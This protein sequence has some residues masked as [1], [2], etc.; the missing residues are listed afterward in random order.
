MFT[1][2]SCT[3]LSRNFNTPNAITPDRLMGLFGVSVKQIS[4]IHSDT[5]IRFHS[6]DNFMVT[7]GHN[8]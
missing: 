1:S 5:G 4:T 7:V 3:V 2:R 8:G 6:N